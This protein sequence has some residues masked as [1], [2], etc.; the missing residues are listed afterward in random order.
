MHRKGHVTTSARWLPHLVS[1]GPPGPGSRSEG[2]LGALRSPGSALPGSLYARCSC[3]GSSPH[4]LSGGSFFPSSSHLLLECFLTKLRMLDLHST[5]ILSPPTV[6]AM[7]L[8]R[9]G[10]TECLSVHSSSVM[11]GHLLQESV[12]VAFT[13]FYCSEKRLQWHCWSGTFS[14]IITWLVVGSYPFAIFQF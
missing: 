5:R 1:G 6:S 13:F 11:R 8:Y 3:A 10:W 2:L 4:A 12:C 7:T 14:N 9:P